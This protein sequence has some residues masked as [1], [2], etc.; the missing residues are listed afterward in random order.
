MLTSGGCWPRHFLPSGRVLLP[1][2]RGR[3]EGREAGAEPGP[4]GQKAAEDWKNSRSHFDIYCEFKPNIQL[5]LTALVIEMQQDGSSV[6]VCVSADVSLEMKLHCS[7]GLHQTVRC[8]RT[9]AAEHHAACCCCLR[10]SGSA[11]K[12]QK[13]LLSDDTPTHNFSPIKGNKNYVLKV[14]KLL[15]IYP[16]FN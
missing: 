5:V 9:A 11:S 7:G 14:S 12:K 1:G 13:A 15:L 4:L 16:P 6:L 2:A 8:G 3:P 10:C